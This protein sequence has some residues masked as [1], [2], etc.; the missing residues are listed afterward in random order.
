MP[1]SPV[2][3]TDSVRLLLSNGETEQAVH[4]LAQ[5]CKKHPSLLD[6]AIVLESSMNN[7]EQKVFEGTISQED[8][9]IEERRITKGVLRLAKMLDQLAEA[10]ALSPVLENALPS[11]ALPAATVVNRRQG[12]VEKTTS[13]PATNKRVFWW[14]GGGVVI[15][16]IV[17][18]LWHRMV[19]APGQPS[20][21]ST[22]TAPVATMETYSGKVLDQHGR[23]LPGATLDFG[24][25]TATTT[26]DADGHFQ[27]S[28]PKPAQEP[29]QVHVKITLNGKVLKNEK[30]WQAAKV[31]GELKVF[32]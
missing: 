18:W 22:S 8:E 29:A 28:L 1:S 16:G 15:L 32:R 26:T 9:N 27:V 10:P 20:S 21:M 13:R 17:V 24:E 23:A 19:E 25:G 14:V 30:L 12:P 11:S 31:L 4:Q 2:L 5:L 7:L 3:P 6:D